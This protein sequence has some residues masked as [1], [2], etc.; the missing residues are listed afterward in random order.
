MGNPTPDE[1][2]GSEPSLV[3]EGSGTAAWPRTAGTAS[4]ILTGIPGSLF[5]I[6]SCGKCGHS[7]CAH[8]KDGVCRICT[9]R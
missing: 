8:G 7:M 4:P 6:S 2:E 3:L 5:V 1:L 9:R